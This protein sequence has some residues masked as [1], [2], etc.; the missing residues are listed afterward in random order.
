VADRAEWSRI[1]GALEL[2][3]S[4]LSLIAGNTAETIAHAELAIS[5]AAEDDHLTRAGAA[6]TAGLA[7]WA[8]GDLEAAHRAYSTSVEG[9]RRA[10]HIS[11]VLGCSITLADIR[12]TQGRLSDAEHTY[13]DA[14]HLAGHEPVPVTRGTA[15]MHVGLSGVTYERNDLETAADHLRLARELGDAAGLP[16]NPYRW[17][18][19]QARLHAA[20]GDLPRAVEHL[21]EAERVYFGDFAPNVRPIAAMRTRLQLAQGDL[22]SATSWAGTIDLASDDEPSYLHEFEHITL[23]M[24]LLAQHR[25]GGTPSAAHDAHQL[26]ER[27]LVAAE[28]GGRAGNVLEV[29]VQM[30]LADE[31][32]DREWA[33][34]TDLLRRALVLAE[35]EGHIRV[36]L[37]AGPH[38]TAV[39]RRVE[40]GSP[41]GQLAREV[42]AAGAAHQPKPQHSGRAAVV[43]AQ[44][45]L[46]DP[47]SERELDILLLL[48][49]DL[50]GPA[51]ARELSVSVNTVRTHTR[52]IYAKLGVTS[53][54]EA[55]REAARLGLL[56]HPSR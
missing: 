55:V 21:N 54:R 7:R 14:L 22:V 31:A 26:L 20:D 43:A 4:A 27:L 1:P 38:L 32:Q 51:I 2:Y 48:D 12:I 49:S 10:G 44:Q 56:R 25:T 42:L 18:V 45:A 52:H 39:L 23:A 33:R 19:A 46:A 53:R 5:R 3:R 17:R 29:L 37:E 15:D 47:L 40:P 50:G 34:A 11:D 35:G 41:G 13:Q 6:A 24:V 8:D 9:L 36:F 30:A 28:H 16:Q